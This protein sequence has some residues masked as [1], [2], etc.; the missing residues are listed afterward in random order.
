MI[1]E[2]RG[3]NFH[4]QYTIRLRGPAEG[5]VLSERQAQKV[6]D[7]QCGVTG[8]ECG[9]MLHYGQGADD[10]SARIVETWTGWALVPA[11]APVRD[12]EGYHQYEA[13]VA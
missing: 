5:F 1:H 8:C 9:G 7:E 12:A 13:V 10:T 4:G 11:P 3:H 6:A 2:V